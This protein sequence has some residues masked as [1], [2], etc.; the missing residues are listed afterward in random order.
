MSTSITDNRVATIAKEELAILPAEE[1]EGDI[2]IIDSLQDVDN[3]LEVL[4]KAS[5]IGFDTETRPSF[6]KGIT[7]KVALMQLANNKT[8][9]LFRLN[10]IGMPD[11]LNDFL[12]DE[13]VTKVGLSIHDDFHNLNKITD[14]NP[15]GFIDLQ[16][17]VKQFKIHDNSLTR[18][19]SILFGKR[20]S[21]GQRL[22]NWEAENLTHNQQMYAAL[23]AFACVKIYNYLTDGNFTVENSP[24]YRELPQPDVTNNKTTTD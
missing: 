18:I 4:R 14:L 16:S 20:I 24:Y 7:H 21:K 5:V 2:I 10:N 17:F 22:T 19:Y 12:E 3:A 8:C 6:K 11:S 23:D 13:S 1:Y 9:Y 15:G